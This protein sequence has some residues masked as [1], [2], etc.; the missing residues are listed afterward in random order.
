MPGFTAGYHVNGSHGV[1]SVPGAPSIGPNGMQ[2]SQPGNY[3][4]S[5]PTVSFTQYSPLSQQGQ[6]APPMIDN[7][8]M[9]GD[10][11]TFGSP[12]HYQS[13]QGQQISPTQDM[14]VTMDSST[15]GPPTSSSFDAS[16]IDPNDPSLFNFNISDLNFGNHYGALE[17]GMLGHISSGAVNTPD[18]DIVNSMGQH[19]SISY[20]GSTSL[21]SNFGYGDQFQPWQATDSGSRQGSTTNLWALQN[22]GVDAF[23]VGEN[24]NS[25]TGASPNSQNQDFGAGY[26]SHTLSPELQFTQP[27]QH[28]QSDATRQTQPQ[29]RSRKPAPFP[30][31]MNQFGFKKRRRDT[32]EIYAAVTR[33]HNYTQGFH[34]LTAHLSKKYDQRNVM[35]IAKALASIRP[36]FIASNK[37]LN[38]DDLIFMEKSFQRTLYETEDHFGATGTPSLVCRRTGEIALVNK[39]F[40]LVTGWRRD[41]L[42]GKEPNLNVNIASS[43]RGSETGGSN[44]RGTATPRN[45]SVE[46]G[47]A[48][49]QAVLIAELM[50]EDSIVQFYRDFSELAFGAA[51]SSVTR[52]VWL[53]KYKTKDD[54]GWRPEDRLAEDGTRVK[55]QNTQNKIKRE[56]LIK[57]EAG[58]KALGDSDGRVDCMLTWTVKR[59]IFETPMLIVMNVSRQS[60]LAEME[61]RG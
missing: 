27:E 16:F 38:E 13:A 43:K 7:Q 20:D 49:P 31:D 9:I 35:E 61:N 33:P 45:P 51:R 23:A 50:D 55:T 53:L 41:V 58:M 59:D 37:N 19:G 17:F 46:T 6:M 30:N 28:H 4:T 47:P 15:L 1:P 2:V 34:N 29:Q 36:S 10:Q 12:T 11:P 48:R 60:A 44:T 14:S 54:P 32:S 25:L 42:L 22:N 5:N 56:P 26:Q 40:S 39:E 24:S 52:R 3:Y 18:L 21:P 57:G 8:G